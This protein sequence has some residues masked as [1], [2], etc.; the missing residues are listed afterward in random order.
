[1]TAELVPAIPFDPHRDPGVAL[2]YWCPWCD[3]RPWEPCDTPW[4]LPHFS[5]TP[6]HSGQPRP[7]TPRQHWQQA[8]EG[9]IGLKRAVELAGARDQLGSLD[10]YLKATAYAL[11]GEA[12]ALLEEAADGAPGALQAHCDVTKD[13]REARHQRRWRVQCGWVTDAADLINHDPGGGDQA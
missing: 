8:I 13:S 9:V 10:R 6:S 5:R 12:M 11:P 1:M 7:R 3:A 4:G 2:R